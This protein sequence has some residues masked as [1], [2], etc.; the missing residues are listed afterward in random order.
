[1][2]PGAIDRGRYRVSA[3][4]FV[5]HSLRTVRSRIRFRC[6]AGEGFENPMKVK[7]THASRGGERIEVRHIL[8]GLDQMARPR[9]CG[10][11]LFGECR[12]VR[13]APFAGSET[14]LFGLCACR[15]ETDMLAACQPRRTGWPAIDASR[16]YRIIE[17]TVCGAVA[18]HDRL[19]PFIVTRKRRRGLRSLCHHC[20]TRLM[21][22]FSL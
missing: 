9:H 20:F 8:S 15:V 12:L 11:V 19:P 3:G 21:H 5:A 1:M 10:G 7:A 6:N 14:S 13:P 17:R 18:S 2:K 22:G 4:E 16:P